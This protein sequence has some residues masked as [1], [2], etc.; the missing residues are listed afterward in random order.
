MKINDRIFS[1]PPYISTSW[2][3]IAALHMR[4]T[5]LIVNMIDGEIVQ[6]PDLKP[7]IIETIFNAHANFLEESLAIEDGSD[8][9]IGAF[10]FQ[11][12]QE[13]GGEMQ[14]PL[15]FGV[16]AMDAWGAALQHNPAQANMPNLP[17]EVLEKVRS[18]SKIISPDDPMAMPKAE[19][20]CNCMHC[21]VA[22]AIS[23][24][25]GLHDMYQKEPIKDDEEKVLD[26]DLAFQQWEI[27]QNKDKVYTV[28]NRLDSDEK[29]SV[30]LGKPI[31]CTCGKEGCEHILAVLKS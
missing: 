25:L 29:Y 31:G 27:Q 22:R 16:G 21:Q 1:F 17:D 13:E 30:Y 28:I 18:I 2:M 20:H 14:L 10:P 24:G 23:Q 7:E 15:K 19:P 26:E 8:P 5:N 4:E 9:S 11:H 6:I 3:N 12:I